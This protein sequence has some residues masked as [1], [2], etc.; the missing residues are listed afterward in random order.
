MADAFA[1]RK[2][3][4]YL[5]FGVIALA[6]IVLLIAFLR[7]GLIPGTEEFQSLSFDIPTAEIDTP[8]NPFAEVS[9]ASPFNI[10]NPF[11]YGNPFG[12]E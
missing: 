8:S 4:T 11:S 2:P 12:G 1:H 7:P 3:L 10:E 9:E 6:I 5:I